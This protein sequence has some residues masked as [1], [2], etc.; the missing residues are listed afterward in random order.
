MA[1]LHRRVPRAIQTSCTLAQLSRAQRYSSSHRHTSIS[2]RCQ[3]NSRQF[4][5]SRVLN[6]QSTFTS[7]L[8]S[9]LK[10]TKIEW[11]PIPIGLGIG[12]LGIFQF[13]RIQKREQRK[14][15]EEQ[16]GEYQ[17]S[18]NGNGNKRPRKRKR[19]KPSGPW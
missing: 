16:E 13:Y 11:R 8:R 6:D 3:E 9:A 2:S 4:S 18:E 12:F 7:R 17:E 5:S 15:L 1:H 10:Q 14:R 19:I